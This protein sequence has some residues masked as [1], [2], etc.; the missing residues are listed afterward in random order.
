MVQETKSMKT[1]TNKS[2][3]SHGSMVNV[4]LCKKDVK[5]LRMLRSTKEN[6]LT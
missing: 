1:V 5:S 3:D 2:K 4:D 6:R